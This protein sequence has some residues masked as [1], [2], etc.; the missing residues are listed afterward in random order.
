MESRGHD[1]H[2]TLGFGIAVEIEITAQI[3]PMI[4]RFDHGHSASALLQGITNFTQKCQRSLNSRPV[5]FSRD[6]DPFRG[7][8]VS[9]HIEDGA[10]RVEGTDENVVGSCERP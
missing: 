4:Q 2:Y 3:G 10:E 7:L 5:F 9:F 1:L 6:L 8:P